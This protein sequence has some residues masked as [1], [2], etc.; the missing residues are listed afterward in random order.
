MPVHEN[1][2]GVGREQLLRRRASNLVTVTHADP[3]TFTLSSYSLVQSRVVRRVSV[4]EDRVN[5]RDRPELI[6]DLVATDITGMQDQLDAGQ[7]F[8]DVGPEQTMR[9]GNQANQDWLIL[10]PVAP[11]PSA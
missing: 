9:V 6:E 4:P 7:R 3:Q 1:V 5:W 8:V 2:L 11:S 10:R